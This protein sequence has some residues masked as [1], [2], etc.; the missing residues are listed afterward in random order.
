MAG[1]DVPAGT[2]SP[3][4]ARMRTQLLLGWPAPDVPSAGAENLAPFTAFADAG[5]TLR[6]RVEDKRAVRRHGF[7]SPAPR[8]GAPISVL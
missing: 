1:A 6:L 7:V 2:L 8:G 4:T 5:S 3:A